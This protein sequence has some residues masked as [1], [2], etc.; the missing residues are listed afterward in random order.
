VDAPCLD[1]GDPITVEM[2]DGRVTSADP[3]G[4]VGH[5]AFGFGPSR[6]RSYYL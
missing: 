4:G 2:R 6:G 3:P 1:C 5:L